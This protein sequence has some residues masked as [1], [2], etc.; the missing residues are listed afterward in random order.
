MRILQ[1]G[2]TLVE[3]MIIVG[4]I[5]LLATIAIPNL[6]RSR[7]NANEAA[8]QATLKSISTALETYITTYDIYPTDTADLI[9][10]S[11]QFLTTNFFTGEHNGYT[12][13]A[14]LNNYT[15]SVTGSPENSSKGNS[16]FTISTGAVLTKN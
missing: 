2:F 1:K 16:S 10:D 6:L 15:Y 9:T 7:I 8:A 13:V 5:A 3:V 11:P 4:I 14:N 12:F